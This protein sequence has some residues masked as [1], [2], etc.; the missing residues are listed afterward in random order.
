MI[1]LLLILSCYNARTA[2]AGNI[3][4]SRRWENKRT[5]SYSV[6]WCVTVGL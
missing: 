5:A 4:P 2:A 1:A 6:A 3:L